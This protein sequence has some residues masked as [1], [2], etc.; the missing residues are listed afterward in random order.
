MTSVAVG[1]AWVFSL[2]FGFERVL[3]TS[4]GDVHGLPSFS[5]VGEWLFP[6]V[7]LPPPRSGG[8]AGVSEPAGPG[9]SRCRQLV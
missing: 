5:F 9:F 2:F 4:L 6:R 1:I 3:C 8:T 7:R